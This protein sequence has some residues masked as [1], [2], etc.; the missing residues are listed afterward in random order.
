MSY[1]ANSRHTFATF[2]VEFCLSGTF[3]QLDPDPEKK[4]GSRPCT[5]IVSISLLQN[6][7]IVF[8]EN[9]LHLLK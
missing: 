8:Q 3:G 5:Y 1:V 4:I 2:K 6:A 9:Q 7:I